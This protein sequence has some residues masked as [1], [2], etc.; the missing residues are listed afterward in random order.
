M[1]IAGGSNTVYI[2]VAA[3]DGISSRVYNLTITRAASQDRQ[4]IVPDDT[5]LKDV[6][7]GDNQINANVAPSVDTYVI[8]IGVSE[9]ATFKVFRDSSLSEE[10]TDGQLALNSGQNTV[11]I[12]VIAEDGS[13]TIYTMN[14]YKPDQPMDFSLIYILVAIFGGLLLLGG[15]AFVVLRRR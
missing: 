1:T 5:Q 9:N 4:I 14:V 8:D 12:V 3:Q 10:I 15:S 7:V 13:E 6:V 11:F 2:K